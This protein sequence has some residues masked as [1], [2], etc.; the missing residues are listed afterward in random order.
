MFLTVDEVMQEMGIE[1]KSRDANEIKQYVAN[2]VKKPASI[3]RSKQVLAEV[4][5]IIDTILEEVKK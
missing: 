1:F 5:D 2:A 3:D 4:L